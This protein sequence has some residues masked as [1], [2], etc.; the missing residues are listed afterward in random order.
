MLANNDLDCAG[1]NIDEFF[2]FM[3]IAYPFVVLQRFNRHLEGLEMFVFSA[4][5]QGLIGIIVRALGV[6]FDPFF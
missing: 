3:L 6:G 2:A 5:R 1:Q 4:G